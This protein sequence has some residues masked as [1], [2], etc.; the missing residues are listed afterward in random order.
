MFHWTCI[1]KTF[2]KTHS[3]FFS[4]PL[5]NKKS[6][7]SVAERELIKLFWQSGW[8]AF[9]AAGSGSAQHAC[10]D[11]IAGNSL[12]KLSVEVKYIDD[13]RK[14][15]SAKEIE[16]LDSFAHTF[17]SEAWVGV[18]FQGKGWYFFTTHDLKE[19]QKGYS[20]KHSDAELKGFTFEQ[21]I[22]TNYE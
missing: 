21:L 17:G 15:F 2:I 10:P 19:T 7:G 5:I 3:S 16:E 20:I 6:K 18:K 14:Y 8:A 13:D 11:V 12:R 4:M 1:Q 22:K 9:R